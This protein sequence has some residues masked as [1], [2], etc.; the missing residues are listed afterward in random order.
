MHSSQPKIIIAIDGFSSCGK[1]TLARQVAK[2]LHYTY[3]DSGAMYRAVTLEAI[4]RNLVDGVQ[5]DEQALSTLL[6]EIQIDFHINKTTGL[7]EIWL[8][9]ENV[10][11]EIRDIEVSDSV[12][13]ISKQEVVRTKLVFLQRRLGKA[14]GIVMDG[15]DIGTVVFPD[16]ELKIFMTADEGVRA[17][18]RYDE[19]IAKGMEVKLESIQKNIHFRDYIDQTREISPLK[20]AE[21]AIELDNSFLSIEETVHQVIDL[22]HQKLRDLNA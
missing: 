21:D 7:Q 10:E 9:G 8:N 19:L 6:D 14:K 15:R 17:K 12:S 5:P 11:E 3:I 4:R 13:I 22:F 20:K 16:A 2:E 1:S 18:R